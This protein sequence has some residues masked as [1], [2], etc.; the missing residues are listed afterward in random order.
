MII[1]KQTIPISRTS[2]HRKFLNS[3]ILL[4]ICLAED[5]Y[6]TGAASFCDD[7][8]KMSPLL[9]EGDRMTHAADSDFRI[10]SSSTK[11]AG[12]SG[13]AALDIDGATTI[14]AQSIQNQWRR[15]RDGCY[16]IFRSFLE[17]TTVHIG[18]SVSFSLCNFGLEFI[19]HTIGYCNSCVFSDSVKISGTRCSDG[20]VVAA[21]KVSYTRLV[22]NEVQ[23]SG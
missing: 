21:S 6:G 4:K 9:R 3:K 1:L 15:R 17:T 2:P 5:F 16:Q 20:G 11:E 12:I 14:F 13:G 19:F 23:H 7:A 18:Y 8:G 22:P 10:Y